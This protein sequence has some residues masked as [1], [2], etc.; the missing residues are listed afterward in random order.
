MMMMMILDDYANDYCIDFRLIQHRCH[1]T[2][3]SCAVDDCSGG[4][5]CCD[6]D[7]IADDLIYYC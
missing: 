4:T 5:G 7:E 2:D 1:D 3:Y 6:D